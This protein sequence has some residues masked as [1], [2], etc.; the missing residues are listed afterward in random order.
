MPVYHSYVDDDGYY[1]TARPSDVGN[2]TYQT[3]TEADTLLTELG[4]RD[5]DDLP[6]GLINP[7]RAAGLIF[8]N[9]QGVKADLDDAPD[10]DPS[11]LDKLSASKAEEL[12]AYFESREDI[13]DEVYNQ[14]QEIIE[15]DEKRE[16]DILGDA[17]SA[18][19][20]DQ[21]THTK[22]IWKTESYEDISRI[23]ISLYGQDIKHILSVFSNN[24]EYKYVDEWSVVHEYGENWE[25]MA[26]GFETQAGVMRAIAQVDDKLSF[27]LMWHEG[28]SNG[29][30]V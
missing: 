13:P 30:R 8:T 23:E 4:Y 1:I 29:Y 15:R 22:L 26:K 25:G 28:L 9:G 11:K 14:L 20:P 10:L 12:L 6:W 5:E 16:A 3:T 21:G 18:E 19:F 2:I 27:D 7:F 17:I 24:T